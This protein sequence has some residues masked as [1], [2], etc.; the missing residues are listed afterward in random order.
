MDEF[1]VIIL[2]GAIGWFWYSSVQ[3]R[4]I[5]ILGARMRCES[6]GLI[7]LDQ[8]VS[9][10]KI[11][12]RRDRSGQ[13]RFEREYQFEFSSNGDDRFEGTITLHGKRISKFSL[14]MPK[15][16]NVGD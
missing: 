15:T 2:L 8:T 12:L 11:R 5:A 13:M 9:L 1:T 14:E 4:D 6:R 7:L 10:F 3:I 16:H